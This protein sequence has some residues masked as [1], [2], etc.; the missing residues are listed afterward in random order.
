[1]TKAGIGIEKETHGGVRL[2]YAYGSG[3][4]ASKASQE[5]SHQWKNEETKIEVHR[6]D[7]KFIKLQY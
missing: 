4:G 6:N 7:L 3:K 2:Q 1:M 5:L